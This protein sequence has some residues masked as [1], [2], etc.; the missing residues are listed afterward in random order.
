MQ[1]RYL[2]SFVLLNISRY[3]FAGRD[4]HAMARE[5]KVKMAGRRPMSSPLPM[6]GLP[7]GVREFCYAMGHACGYYHYMLCV[8]VYLCPWLEM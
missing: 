2:Y 5:L 3:A 8:Q 1:S 4:H 7:D 6:G